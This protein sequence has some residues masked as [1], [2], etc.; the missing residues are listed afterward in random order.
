MTCRALLLSGSIGSGH[1][2]MAE[3]LADE[4]ER[5]RWRTRTVDCMPLLGER[6]G[7]V[8]EAVFRFLLA[9]PGLYDAYHFAALRPG[10]ALALRT[11]AA[12]RRRLLPRLA[13]L[14]AREQPDLVV[15]VFP[16]GASAAAALARDGTVPALAVFC[17]DVTPHRLWVHEGVDAYLVT[18]PVAVA[19]VRRYQPGARV[20]V[21]PPPVRAGFRRPPDRARA[22]EELR[23]PGDEPCVLLMGGAWGMGPMHEAALAL[24][25]AGTHV[26][27]VAGRN[28]R[29]ERRLRGAARDL[30][31]LHPFGF[32]DQVPPLMSACDLVVTTSGDTCSEARA[33][34]RDLL[35]LDVVAGHGR[36]NLQHELEQGHAAVVSADP[37]IMHEAVRRLLPEARPRPAIDPTPAFSGIMDDLL[38]ALDLDGPRPP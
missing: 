38:A 34:G 11:D 13:E 15:A 30:P 28:G 32:T 27:A 24:A 26:L 36:D 3:A 4:L 9:T 17:T 33:L 6:A 19:G 23:I 29:L 2:V 14:V 35:L 37:E 12:A 8:G 10:N 5:R 18:S 1:D 20:L 7:R 16:T 22:R 21:T 31:T 25:G